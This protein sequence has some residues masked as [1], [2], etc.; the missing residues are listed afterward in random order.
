M[1]MKIRF[2]M[3]GDKLPIAGISKELDNNGRYVYVIK[4]IEW[5]ETEI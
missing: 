1:L 4:G 5:V 3:M 2:K